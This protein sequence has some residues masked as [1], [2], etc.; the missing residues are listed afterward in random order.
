MPIA[1]PL[2]QLQ[3]VA[4]L[5]LFGVAV[6][7]LF[8]DEVLGP[9]LVGL[10]TGTAEATAAL[11]HAVG[12]EAIR[13]GTTIS[14]PGGLAVEIS[15]GCTGLVGAA[16][17]AVAIFAYPADRR[18]RV[19]G[20]MICVPLFV[21]LNF[22]RLVNLFYLGVYKPIWFDLAHDLLWEAAMVV[23]IYAMWL[24]WKVWA[25]R[26]SARISPASAPAPVAGLTTGR[27]L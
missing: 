1:V 13:E 3:F 12:L 15:R 24:S 5:I 20:A 18:S 17:L 19:V 21:G 7:I 11:I 14:H 10:R 9:A 16:L 26:R 4:V 25:D 27:H 6:W 2:R 23:G 8:R 22:V